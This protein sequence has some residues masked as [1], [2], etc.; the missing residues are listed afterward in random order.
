MITYL[1][2]PLSNRIFKSHNIRKQ[3]DTEL[4]VRWV[5]HDDSS[6]PEILANS[7]GA[8]YITRDSKDSDS[9][10]LHILIQTDMN[11]SLPAFIT[12]H[13]DKSVSYLIDILK[14]I[15]KAINS[16]GDIQT[17]KILIQEKIYILVL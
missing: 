10:V 3:T 6:S 12:T 1:P 11:G 15:L 2:F 17:E 16:N 8:F 9:C 7:T 13:L 5:H 4:L 14:N